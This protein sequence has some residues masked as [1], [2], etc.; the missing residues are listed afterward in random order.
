VDKIEDFQEKTEKKGSPCLWPPQVL[1]PAPHE[2]SEYDCIDL[3]A[4]Q[5]PTP[6]DEDYADYRCV[7]YLLRRL[8]KIADDRIRLLCSFLGVPPHLPIARQ[9]WV[10]FRY[11][12]R[13]HIYLLYDRHVDHWI[14]CCLYGV[15]KALKYDS[16]L[17]FARIIDAYVVI[18]GPEFGDVTCQRIL[19]HIKIMD[20]APQPIGDIIYLYNQV[21]LWKVHKHLLRSKCIQL[22]AEE[23]ESSKQL[24]IKDDLQVILNSP[25]TYLR[26]MQDN[27]RGRSDRPAT[28]TIIEMGKAQTLPPSEVAPNTEPNQ[29][30]SSTS[31]AMDES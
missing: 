24:A 27:L 12:L 3:A 25:A 23:I 19:R 20:A 9:V 17:T 16:N 26:L 10:A 5:Y 7:S 18:R 15:C 13:N 28:Q 29:I 6:E 22:A 11:I 21:F 31:E 30:D 2:A 1:L 4:R 14:V 8:L